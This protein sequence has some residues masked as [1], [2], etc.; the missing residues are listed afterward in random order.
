[1]RWPA[2]PK[3]PTEE[4]SFSSISSIYGKNSGVEIKT[5]ASLKEMVSVRI[6]TQSDQWWCI[7]VSSLYFKRSFKSQSISI[8]SFCS[9]VPGIFMSRGSRFIWWHGHFLCYQFRYATIPID[10]GVDVANE[11]CKWTEL[12]SLN[13]N[14]FFLINS[15]SIL[16]R[17]DH[18]RCQYYRKMIL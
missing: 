12:F 3:T 17:L 6:P 2:A 1:M 7:L 15:D 5:C 11:K 16:N 10:S 9:F 4:K 14:Q 8:I 13:L 18:S